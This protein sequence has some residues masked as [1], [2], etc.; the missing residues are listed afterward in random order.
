MF[1]QK[2]TSFYYQ[3]KLHEDCSNVNKYASYILSK[4]A[5]NERMVKAYSKLYRVNLF[6]D[7]DDNYLSYKYTQSLAIRKTVSEW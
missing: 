5:C 7:D 1:L 4:I 6:I 3:Y 2:K